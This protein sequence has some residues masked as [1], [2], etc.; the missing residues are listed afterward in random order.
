MFDLVKMNKIAGHYTR[1]TRSQFGRGCDVYGV[2]AVVTVQWDLN[3][4]FREA[5]VT[6]RPCLAREGASYLH[7][8]EPT[9]FLEAIGFL[10]IAYLKAI[11]E[12]YKKL[13]E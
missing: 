8:E 5:W 11:D 3:G 10:P 13:F 6:I 1:T 4:D 7:Y 9:V 2:A 12:G